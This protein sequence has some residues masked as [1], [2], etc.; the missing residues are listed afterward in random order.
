M[1]RGYEYSRLDG[2][3]PHEERE[4]RTGQES[5]A[6]RQKLALS[7]TMFLYCCFQFW[8][9]LLLSDTDFLTATMIFLLSSLFHT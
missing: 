3:T 8:S 1:W 5:E 6:R 9:A 4:V 2:Q 7:C